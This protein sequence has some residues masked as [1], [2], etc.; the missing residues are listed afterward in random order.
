MK[1]LQ[2][3]GWSG[4]EDNNTQTHEIMAA[5]SQAEVAR[6]AGVKSPARLWNLGV[7]ANEPEIA[8]ALAEPGVIFWFPL[9]ERN[10]HP[11]WRRRVT[12]SR[13]GPGRQ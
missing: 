3:W 8:Q 10:H 13:Y 12:P 4:W 11:R 1:P 5:H 7:T 6:A 9:S 2:V